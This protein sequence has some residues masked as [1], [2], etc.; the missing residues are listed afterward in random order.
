MAAAMRGHAEVAALL[1]DHGA[2]PDREN[3]LGQTA[4]EIAAGGDHVEVLRLLFDRGAGI[5]ERR[6]AALWQ[7]AAVRN[8]PCV[9]A[10]LHQRCPPVDQAHAVTG[11]TPLLTVASLG[12]VDALRV[13]LGAGADPRRWSAEGKQA[14]HLAPDAATLQLLLDAGVGLNEPD[15]QGG[16]ALHRA[17]CS[18]DPGC[19]EWLLQHGADVNAVDRMRRTGLLLA[20]EHGN[21][22]ERQSGRGTGDEERKTEAIIRLLLQ[23]GAEVNQSDAAGTT[24]LMFALALRS[25]AGVAQLLQQPGLRLDQASQRGTTA[26]MC[27]VAGAGDINFL[28]DSNRGCDVVRL[29]T[30]N[31]T[32]EEVEC[33]LQHGAAVNAVNREGWSP[34]VFAARTGVRELV[35]RLLRAGADKSMVAAVG[36]RFNTATLIRQAGLG[37]LLV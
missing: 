22:H 8:A 4:L 9:L 1:L 17:V 37:Y 25:P 32:A 21:G 27:A 29:G 14:V 35:E 26:L 28:F 16:T 10:F 11:R 13:L 18:L 34:L 2:D 23:A 33:L 15:R 6:R 20:C 36:D 7:Q 30:P 3:C 31:G 5:D 24:P 12:N 19:V